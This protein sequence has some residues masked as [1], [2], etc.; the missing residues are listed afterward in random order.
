MDCF[1]IVLLILLIT[2]AVGIS[3]V[4]NLISAVLVLACL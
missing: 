2:T 4:R 3:R 1:E